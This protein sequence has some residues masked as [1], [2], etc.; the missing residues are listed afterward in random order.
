MYTSVAD[1]SAFPDTGALP[2]EAASALVAFVAIEEASEDVDFV[3]VGPEGGT[4]LAAEVLVVDAVSSM[5]ARR[6]T[7]CASFT[8]SLVTCSAITVSGTVSAEGSMSEVFSV[9]KENAETGE[10]GIDCCEPC[11]GQCWSGMRARQEESGYIHL[12]SDAT[13]R[14]REEL[15][16]PQKRRLRSFMGDAADAEVS[17]WRWSLGNGVEASA[18]VVFVALGVPNGVELRPGG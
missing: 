7:D 16:L 6:T 18:S 12:V 1:P 4:P 5:G 14:H 3:V 10:M 2:A 9:L 8:T 15:A 11:P 13:G 17:G